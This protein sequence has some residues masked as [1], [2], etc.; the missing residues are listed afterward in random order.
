MLL[1]L[2]ILHRQRLIFWIWQWQVTMDLPLSWGREK[3]KITR[4]SI[5]AIL[6]IIIIIVGWMSE[7]KMELLVCCYSFHSFPLCTLL[8]SSR[9]NILGTKLPVASALYVGCAWSGLSGL[10][11]HRGKY[12]AIRPF[13]HCSPQYRVETRWSGESE[14]WAAFYSKQLP[15]YLFGNG[16]S[17]DLLRLSRQWKQLSLQ[18]SLFSQRAVLLN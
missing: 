14:V 2:L 12:E 8:D 1:G 11:G 5:Q 16:S 10:S 9:G 3:Q 7:S 4:K 18:G 17:S 13:F 15:K 6:S